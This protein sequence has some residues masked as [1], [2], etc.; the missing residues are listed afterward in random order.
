MFAVQT[1]DR[2]SPAGLSLFPKEL[3]NVGNDIKQPDAL[4]L[5]SHNL[6][7]S[8]FLPSIRVVARAG[9]GT[10]NIPIAK[11]T[12]QGIPVLFAPG[13]NANAVKELVIAS[14]LM[15]CRRLGQANEFIHS[16][17]S[18]E[19]QHYHHEIETG[20]K[21]FVGQEIQGRTLGVIG[22][23]HIGVQVANA[24]LSLGMRVIGYDPLMSIENA[25]AL[26]PRV[27][28]I[29]HIEALLNTAEFITVHVPLNDK[30]KHYINAAR[31]AQMR[32]QTYLLNFSRAGIVDEAAVLAALTA[33]KIAYYITDFPTPELSQQPNVLCLPHL[34]AST[35]EAE[36]NCAT[37]ICKK[38]RD[39]LENGTIKNSV[40]FPDAELPWLPDDNQIRLAIT[41]RNIPGAIAEISQAL[42]KAGLNITQMVN[43][44]SHAIAY[45]LIDVTAEQDEK[46]LKLVAT[47]PD[48]LQ[49][50]VI[51]YPAQS[52]A[53][54]S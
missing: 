47:L 10:D 49:A 13:A 16:I 41:N 32:D 2:I 6:H 9:I 46:L 52:A 20:K 30:T 42:S 14:L 38:I 34:G 35:L 26:S 18:S 12:E 37:I 3:Y 4:L 27:E 28:K 5:R 33:K 29:N 51:R 23:G 39:F 24:A 53:M 25:L 15:G 31:L 36:E 19:P 21:Q 7:Q 54:S 40:N 17:K 44:S 22:L 48:V 1:L 45:N 50:R 43:H 11:L 8:T